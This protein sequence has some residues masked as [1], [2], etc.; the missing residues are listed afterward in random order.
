MNA[1]IK[2]AIQNVHIKTKLPSV[3][4]EDY[5]LKRKEN[6]IERI[7]EGLFNPLEAILHHNSSYINKKLK[8]Y[9]LNTIIL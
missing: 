3:V 9:F 2:I 6:L 7:T 4:N 5:L 1:P 8:E